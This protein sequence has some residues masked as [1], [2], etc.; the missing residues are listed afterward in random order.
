MERALR[1]LAEPPAPAGETRPAELLDLRFR[2]L[3]P[4]A[5]WARLPPAVRRRF[6]KRLGDGES[7]VYAGRVVETRL[8]RAGWW[9]AQALR[10]VGAPLPTAPVANVPSVVAV[11]Q[12]R[13]GG[14]QI[15]TR[16]YARAAGFPQAIHSAKRFRGPTGL[17]EHVGAG[18]GMSLRVSVED[19][20]LV[21]RS[22]RYFVAAFGLR[23]NLPGWLTPGTLTVTHAATGAHAFRFDLEIRHPRL[24]LLL[25]QEAE[26]A[27]QTALGG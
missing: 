5:D 12:D 14:G 27:D 2:A 6:S 17:E 9:L 10:P 25:R 3:V 21:F 23:L 13:A 18:L 26:F 15:W 4:E 11:T 20:A 22:E 8:S 1:P 16:L 24:G 7:A 19:G